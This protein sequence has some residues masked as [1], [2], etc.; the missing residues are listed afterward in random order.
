MSGR[1]RSAQWSGI[2]LAFCLIAMAA[3]A[4]SQ[5]AQPPEDR[6]KAVDHS[7]VFPP[8]PKQR[9]ASSEP[10]CGTGAAEGFALAAHQGWDL[11]VPPQAGTPNSMSAPCER[12]G[13]RVGSSGGTSSSR[14]VR[15]RSTLGLG[16]R[17]AT[18][19]SRRRHTTRNPT[20]C[21]RRPCRQP[22][23]VSLQTPVC[24]LPKS[25]SR[26]RCQVLPTNRIHLTQSDR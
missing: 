19:R 9:A 25:R 6:D 10:R 21:N 4:Q 12:K 17:R 14:P 2:A 20:R 18:R 16:T 8:V 26:L 5:D 11:A 13:A 23:R 22:P 3:S 24:R 1:S 7:P 15:R